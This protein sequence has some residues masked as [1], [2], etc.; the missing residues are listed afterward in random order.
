[1]ST[2]ESPNL[3]DENL[4]AEEVVL[5]EEVDE[6]EEET[7]ESDLV[8][9]DF[10]EAEKLLAQLLLQMQKRNKTSKK[11]VVQQ[12]AADRKKQKRSEHVVT[13]ERGELKV[14]TDA[15]LKSDESTELILSMSSKK[16]LEG[17]VVGMRSVNTNSNVSTWLAEVSW[18][19]D[20]FTILIPSYQLFDYEVTDNRSEQE[21]RN[22]Q[23]QMQSM[24]GA[25]IPFVVRHVDKR[26][27]IA[28]ASRL[29]ALEMIA[30]GNYIAKTRTGKPR[31]TV[32]A[33]AE[34]QVIG[35]RNRDL[36]VNVLGADTYIPCR[37]ED[38]R[39]SWDYIPDLNA[40]YNIGDFVKV[41][42]TAIKPEKKVKYDDKYTLIDIKASIKD[43]IE[44]PLAKYWDT[45]VPGE[46][47][48][49]TVTAVTESGIFV[50]YKDRFTVLCKCPERGSTPYVGQRR[51][52][53]ITLKVD[54]EIPAN[55]KVFGIFASN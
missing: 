19:H 35:I 2:L 43:C 18:G 27:S 1:M 24:L 29:Q 36:W 50:R 32:G 53:K 38:N 39:V 9:D 23:M 26:K 40:A 44:P 7:T 42:V 37:F 31:V 49:A 48:I 41:K 20:F 5:D 34:A 15:T 25:T 13:K 52:V 8:L 28:Y 4:D 51:T 47:G 54:N 46:I 14:D 12:T 21:E 3:E 33:I 30:K 22:I 11:S 6:M 16:V 10:D 55:R 17:T 45:I